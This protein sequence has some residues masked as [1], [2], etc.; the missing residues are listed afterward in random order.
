MRKGKD[1]LKMIPSYHFP[2]ILKLKNLPTR[3]IKREQNSN[4]NLNKLRAGKS[5][6]NYN[7]QLK[8]N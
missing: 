5:L 4:W 3:R 2:L 6:K 1:R 8:K 7:Q